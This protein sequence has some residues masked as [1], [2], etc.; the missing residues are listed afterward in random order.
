MV[1]EGD[2]FIDCNAAALQLFGCTREQFVGQTPQRFS[3][4][5]QPDER[6]SSEK[7]RDMVQAALEHGPQRFEWQ[8]IRFDGTFFDAEVAL[9]R[10]DT[11][12]EALLVAVVRDIT[13][14]KRL[15]DAVHNIAA[16]ISAATGQEYFNLLVRY[17]ARALGASTA[18]VGELIGEGRICTAAVVTDG[19]LGENFE[20]DLAETPCRMVVGTRLCLYPRDVQQE[21]PTDVILRDLD[22]ESYIGVPLFDS[23]HQPLGLLAAVKRTPIENPAFAEYIMRIFAARTAGE[24][25]RKRSLQKLLEEKK[26]TETI[27]NSV[28]GIFFMID[29]H[30]KS[31]WRNRALMEA[32]GDDLDDREPV[33]PLGLVVDEDKETVARSIKDGFEKGESS[34]ELR[35]KH[36][37]GTFHWYYCTARR[38]EMG[39]SEYLVGGGIDI[40]ELRQAQDALRESENH[41]RQFYRET[42]FSVTNG[43]LTIC[44][45]AEI[46]AHLLGATMT[47]D[48]GDAQDLTTARARI[49][50]FCTDNGLL[51]E[52]RDLFMAGVGEATTNVIKHASGGAVSAGIAEGAVWVGVSD[53]GPGIEHLT[54]PRVLLLRGFSTK[55]SLGIGYTVMLDVADRIFL[56][57]GAEGTTVILAKEIQERPHYPRL[58]QLPDTWAASAGP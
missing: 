12:Q 8:H 5:L 33:D 27:V 36:P 3:P 38:V 24:L 26:L 17:V 29:R 48:I 51:G 20:Y 37:N 56:H 52:R 6:E 1:L 45:R 55:P 19:V 43:K 46:E 40:T 58:E 16:G 18:F 57:T 35:T 31:V 21:F 34:V 44:D 4:R 2:A 50:E 22:A 39:G 9:T 7:A 11:G 32:R 54:L 25:E 10:V 41:K 28:P 47:L 13:E 23:S 14:R 42:I 53:S 30:G 15:Q 49:R